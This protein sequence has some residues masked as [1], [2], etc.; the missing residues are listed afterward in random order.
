MLKTTLLL[1][2]ISLGGAAAA[3]TLNCW[4]TNFTDPKSPFM[5]ATIVGNSVLSNITFNYKNSGEE[6]TPGHVKPTYIDPA[7]KK[8]THS[9]YKGNNRYTLK[10]GDTLVLPVDLSNKN[11]KK[12]LKKGIGEYKDENGAIIGFWKDGDSEG[13]NHYSVRLNCESDR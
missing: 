11:L 3:D 12:V 7:D 13:G 6:N 4:K 9:P 8:D 10:N 5:S 2:V 1:L